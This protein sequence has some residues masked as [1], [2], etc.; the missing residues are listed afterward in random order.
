[1]SKLFIHTWCYTTNFPTVKL[2]NIFIK[3]HWNTVKL[4]SWH[5]AKEI[6]MLWLHTPC[7]DI[8]NSYNVI[9][10][11]HLLAWIYLQLDNATLCYGMVGRLKRA[12]PPTSSLT[13]LRMIQS[14][15]SKQAVGGQPPR[16]A[17]PRP[18]TEA[19]S[20]SLEP[21]RPSWARPANMRHPAGRPN[22]PPA[23]RMYATDVK[24]TDVRQH[25]HLMPLGEGI[26]NQWRQ[27]K[28]ANKEDTTDKQ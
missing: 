3:C 7:T 18:A 9:Y 14:Q 4:A 23:D 22:M 25:H 1:M 6:T 12:L 27:C 24:Q 8:D 2:Q 5:R 11:Y 10:D 20:G 16:Y 21:G 28:M 19:C 17:P 26:I 13:G 15:V